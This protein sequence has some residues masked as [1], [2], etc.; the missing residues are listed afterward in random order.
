MAIKGDA[1]TVTYFAWDTGNQAGKT[2]DNGNHT[3]RLVRDGVEDTPDNSPAE[4]DA[5]NLPG[6]YSLALTETEMNADAVTLG[7]KSST[8]DIV[9]VPTQVVTEGGG[10][11]ALNDLS[12]DDVNAECDT[13][14]ADYDGPTKTEMDA[15]F[16]AQTGADADTL[17]I[18]SDQ[19]DAIATT[20]DGSVAVDHDTGGA[21]NLAYKT[22]GGVGINNATIKVYTTT[23]YDAGNWDSTYVEAQT[24]T[25]VNGR[26]EDVLHLDPA[27]YTFLYIKQGEYGPDTA[28]QAVS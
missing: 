9:I 28:E 27:T 21:D 11:A 13:A 18:L 5:T 6:V 19:I 23:N 16:L 1:L 2:G 20:G 10:F 22:A 14:L 8:A 3:L 17:E 24:T 12:A 15:A 7:G 25:D 4:V 26:F